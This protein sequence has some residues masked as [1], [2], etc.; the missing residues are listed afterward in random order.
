MLIP[1]RVSTFASILE[2]THDP[3]RAPSAIE[4]KIFEFDAIVITTSGRWEFRGSGGASDVDSGALV[5]GAAGAH[6][7]C[8]HRPRVRDRNL[9]VALR[10]GALDLD[11]PPLFAKQVVPA[12]SALRLAR[13]AADA[14]TP[15]AFDSLVFALFDDASALSRGAAQAAG[16]RLR[17]QRAKRFIELHAFERIGIADI[18][19]ELALSPFTVA[20][21]FRSATGKSPYAYLLEL[22]LARAKELL[23]DTDDLVGAVACAVGIDDAA[24]FAHWFTKAAGVAPSVYRA[25]ARA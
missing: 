12:G 5:L 14:A 4:D 8:R 18:A 10:P 17:M 16:S 11:F 25:R 20:H 22:R 15:D 7:G 1:A 6:Y 2:Y 9:V 24:R 21:Q 23:R 13:R 3:E 19:R